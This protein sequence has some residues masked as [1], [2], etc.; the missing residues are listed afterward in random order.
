MNRLLRG[1]ES[2]SN[3]AKNETRGGRKKE[4]ERTLKLHRGDEHRKNITGEEE[5]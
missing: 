4:K 5:E 3:Q 2:I 1:D